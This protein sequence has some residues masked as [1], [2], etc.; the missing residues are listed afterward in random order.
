M[1]QAFD[2]PSYGAGAAPSNSREGSLFSRAIWPSLMLGVPAI[3]SALIWAYGADFYELGIDSRV[4]HSQ[5]RVLSPGGMVGHGYGIVGTALFLTNLTYLMRR[6]FARWRVG[7]MKLWLE[8]HAVTGILGGALILFHSAFQL[9]SSIASTSFWCVVVLMVT[10]IIGRFLKSLVPH[11]NLTLLAQGLQ[12]LDAQVPGLGKALKSE[13]TSLQPSP[14][15][16]RH[17]LPKTLRMLPR[18]RR[19][20][21]ERRR[22]VIAAAEPFRFSASDR[23]NLLEPT[24]QQ[25]ATIAY[26]EL[27]AHAADSLLRAW[28]GFHRFAALLMT[29]T[30]IVHIAIAWYYGFRWIWSE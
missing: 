2:A 30:V 13:L 1:S 7:K 4:D 23:F 29:F 10:G 26:N 28:R 27:R 3:A 11:P 12:E 25:C 14:I 21:V 8:I 15:Q 18:W 22:S 16:G 19:E 24:V 17:T 20:A 9:R 5:F 6:R